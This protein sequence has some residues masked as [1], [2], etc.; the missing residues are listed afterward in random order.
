MGSF[1]A[2]IHTDPIEYSNSDKSLTVSVI[3]SHEPPFNWNG[4]SFSKYMH[5]MMNYMLTA[6]YHRDTPYEDPCVKW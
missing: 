4:G 6:S 1:L 5:N 3:L 2:L